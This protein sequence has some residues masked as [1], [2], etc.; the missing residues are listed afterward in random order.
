MWISTLSLGKRSG[1]LNYGCNKTKEL[2]IVSLYLIWAP[3]NFVNFPHNLL[4]SKSK[5]YQEINFA[6][7]NILL[8]F[9]AKKLRNS[10]SIAKKQ[11]LEIKTWRKKCMVFCQNA[12]S[13]RLQICWQ[14]NIEYYCKQQKRCYTYNHSITPYVFWKFYFWFKQLV[15]LIFDIWVIE[16]FGFLELTKFFLWE[17]GK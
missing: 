9:I 2:L 5:S 17:C 8:A 15:K 16:N 1:I 7:I 6:D 11:C 3:V 14:L 12:L 13:K 10:K 4:R